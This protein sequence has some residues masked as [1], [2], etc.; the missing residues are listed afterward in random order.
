MTETTT[1]ADKPEKKR[2]SIWIRIGIFFS[3]L[4]IIIL[5]AAYAYG[6]FELM[7][8]NQ[9]FSQM[10]NVTQQNASNNSITALENSVSEIQK[11]M[12]TSQSEMSELRTIATGDLSK[13]HI[14]QAESLVKMANDQLQYQHNI[15]NAIQLLQQAD[16][17]LQFSQDSSLLA[18]R[19]S[20]ATDIVNLQSLQPVDITSIYLKL[21]ALHGLVNKLQLPIQPLKADDTSATSSQP[22]KW[23]DGLASALDALSKVVIIRKNDASAL[24]LVMP[25]EKIFLYQNLHAQLDNATWGLLHGNAE[26]Y[27]TSLARAQAWIHQYF[28]Q[29]NQETQSIQQQL[30]DLQKINVLPPSASLANTLQLFDGYRASPG[31]KTS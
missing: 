13:L 8:I 27:V 12:Q 17:E 2:G 23:K 25:D 5:I 22:S 26:I 7:R 1:P 14:A 4:G 11:S 30:T 10:S 6:Y 9:Q 16:K 24:P 28:V 18:I 19:K 31:Q 29:E 21:D 20:I 15:A 3:M